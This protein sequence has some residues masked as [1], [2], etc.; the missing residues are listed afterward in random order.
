MSWVRSAGGLPDFGMT[1]LLD[2]FRR[3]VDAPACDCTG[4][5]YKDTRETWLA[6][7]WFDDPDSGR[8][9]LR[10]CCDL[11][12]REVASAQRR[13]CAIQAERLCILRNLNA[14]RLAFPEAVR[15]LN[16]LLERPALE[17][18]SVADKPKPG[19]LLRRAA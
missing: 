10:Y 17:P 6:I 16:A 14:G 9:P 15:A 11:V 1:V 4:R 19:S 5:H 8:L 3:L 18:D 12:G 13:A 2:G 7:A